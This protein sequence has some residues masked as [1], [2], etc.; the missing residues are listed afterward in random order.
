VSSSWSSSALRRPDPRRDC[1]R[2][3]RPRRPPRRRHQ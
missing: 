3:H 2:P 1:S